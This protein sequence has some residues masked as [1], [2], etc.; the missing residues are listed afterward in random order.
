[1]SNTRPR[2]SDR[3]GMMQGRL[4]PLVDGKI[5]AFPWKDWKAEFPQ[6]KQLSLPILEWTL[7]HE[8][9]YDNPLLKSDGR[10]EIKRL[11]A[12]NVVSVQAL[13]GDLFM[14]APF[15]KASSADA[16][17]LL[18][19]LD[20]V[21]DACAEMAIAIIVI[22]LVDNG[23]LQDKQQE[24]RLIEELLPRANA[25][26]A[27]GI[28]IAFES[29]FAPA[30][31]RDL[32]AAFP[33]NAFGINYDIGNSA[34]LGYNCTEEIAT[35]GARIVHVHV[36]DRIRGGTTVPLGTGAADL[37]QAIRALEVSGY[38]GRYVLQTARAAD[39]N[40]AEALARYRDMTLNWIEAA[41]DGPRT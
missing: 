41:A 23:S 25:L 36:K 8:G 12:E 3:I 7:D 39:G 27:R 2:P 1:M 13:T 35:Y 10:A 19:N 38:R 5:Q 21:L 40:H 37:G 17:A 28:K 31:L 11:C 34:A 20:D 33:E 6:M 32:I 4:S 18:R 15:W 30:R 16:K 24:K 14:Q 22:P 26:A 9:L 29:D